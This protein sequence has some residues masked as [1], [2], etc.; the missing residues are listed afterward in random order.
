MEDF[1]RLRIIAQELSK[2][3]FKQ[4][5][6]WRIDIDGAPADFDF[7]A[8]EITF[9]PIE[10]ETEADKL[11]GKVITWP[12]GAAPVTISMTMRDHED[13]R[14]YRWFEQAAAR[15]FVGNTGLFNM[16][17]DYLLTMR[18][19]AIDSNGGETLSDQWQ[20]YPTQ[21]GD[22]TESREDPGFLEF[23]ITFT[24]FASLGT[25]S[26]PGGEGE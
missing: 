19:Y 22:V 12:T 6:Q 25:I 11:G 24:Q 1:N 23:P 16:P 21:L 20:V 10:I 8:K 17:V 14:I 2:I 3:P 5:W 9:G 15:I 13:R 26:A 7:Y 18:R 4:S